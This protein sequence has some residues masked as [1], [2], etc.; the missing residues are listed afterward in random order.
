MVLHATG[1]RTTCSTPI[2]LVDERILPEFKGRLVESLGRK[3][4]E[5]ISKQTDE[6]C[7]EMPCSA[8]GLGAGKYHI[9]TLLEIEND[10]RWDL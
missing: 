10:T 1:N 2:H 4:H 7:Q 3:N 8:S 5:D 6:P 9:Y